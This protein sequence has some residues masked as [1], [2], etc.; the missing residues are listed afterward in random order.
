MIIL[1]ENVNVIR[2]KTKRESN[3]LL[4]ILMLPAII[5]LIIFKFIPLFGGI[6][7]SFQDFKLSAG[8]FGKQE[9]VGWDNYK[10]ILSLP[11]I[12]NIILNTI[13]IAVWKLVLLLIVPILISLL[14]NEIKNKKYKKFL[15]TV[16]IMPHFISWILLAGVYQNF[17]AI[18]GFFN[19][20]L[21]TIGLEKL[22]VFGDPTQYVNFVISSDVLKEY[23]FSC[24]VYLAA[25][26]GIDQEQYEAAK[27]DGCGRFRTMV[28][29]T[30]PNISPIIFLMTVLSLGN[31]FNAGFDQI[32]NTYNSA[33]TSKGQVLDTLIYSM[34]M[35]SREYSLSAAL[36]LM[37]STISTALMGIAYYIAYKKNGYLI[38]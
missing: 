29:I 11:D 14:L 34:G 21:E 8:F 37:K 12:G 22:F 31:V 38:F 25:I 17:F 23:G 4:H 27:V 16:I 1:N 28:H 2:T 13:Y 9:F 10:Y 33:V 15:T 20:F 26:A 30:L 19:T 6:M 36:G 35:S 3:F 18:D 5:L 32:Y 7:M 24:I